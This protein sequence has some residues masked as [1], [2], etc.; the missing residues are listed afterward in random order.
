MDFRTRRQ[1]V[2]LLAVG[3][4][5]AGIAAAALRLSAPAPSCADNR[6]NQ[7]EEAADCGGP[8][9]PCALKH[10]RALEVFWV[11]FVKVRENTYDVAAEVRNPNPKLGAPAFAYEFKLYDTAGALV[12]AR[13]GQAFLYP[14]ETAHLAEIGL[15][16]G[17]QIQRAALAVGEADWRF[18]EGRAPDVAAGS[19][20]YATVEEEG[21]TRGRARA[22]VANR[23]LEDL[24]EVEVSAVILDR[25]GNLL[26]VHRTLLQALPAGAARPV[27]F[28]WPAAFP[29]SAAAILIEP[30]TPLGFPTSP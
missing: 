22:I 15:T 28:V 19:R 26:G 20:E 4:A 17:R 24:P 3:L 18:M 30:R 1:L 16:S 27:E 6:K 23:T 10:P 2:V 21:T 7:G 14:G 8:C 11:R 9:P 12:A 5:A 13:A 29:R 25:D